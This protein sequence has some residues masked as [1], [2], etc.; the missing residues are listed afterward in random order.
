M[1]KLSGIIA[2]IV[3]FLFA[4]PAFAHVIVSPTQVGIGAFQ[5]F[6]LG[7]P[8]EKDEPTVGLKLL[9]PKGL[10]EVTPN[11]KPGWVVTEKKQG[12]GEA[13]LVTEIDWANGSIPAGE[14]DEFSFSAQ[15]PSQP[16]TL[17][18][19]AYQTYQDGSVVAWDQKPGTEKPGEEGTP[20]SQTQIINDLTNQKPVTTALS[21]GV[22]TAIAFSIFA[23]LLSGIALLLQ[24]QKK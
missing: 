2:I 1:K 20:Y 4:T 12:S 22:N 13:A 14:R 11:V 3:L 18:W 8:S 21:N 7:V 15:V 5:T 17:D 10:Q 9:L 23:V 16:T 19:K 24:L 6:T